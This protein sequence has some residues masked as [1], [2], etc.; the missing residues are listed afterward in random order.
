MVVGRRP[1]LLFDEQLLQGRLLLRRRLQNQ[2]Q[3]IE[4]ERRINRALIELRPRL[5]ADVA[6][7]HYGSPR[8]NWHDNSVLLRQKRDRRHQQCASG[9]PTRDSMQQLHA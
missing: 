2:S 3:E 6:R 7:Q 8:F 9:Y 5:R 1:A 4:L